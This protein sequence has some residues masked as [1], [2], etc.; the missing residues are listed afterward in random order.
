[1]IA[2]LIA[3]G[4]TGCG[5]DDESGSEQRG[6]TV[7]LVPQTTPAATATAAPPAATTTTRRPPTARRRAKAQPLA[8]VLRPY[9]ARVNRRITTVNELNVLARTPVADDFLLETLDKRAGEIFQAVYGK[10]RQKR[11]TTIVFRGDLN[12]AR[13]GRTLRNTVAAIY[14]MQATRARQIDFGSED[15]VEL[16]DW[17][18]FR[19]TVHPLLR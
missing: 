4:A 8:T 3:T 18:P 12:D 10:A 5:A 6:R 15:V 17:S 13:R 2:T 19:L 7:A 16:T 9:D 11:A 1:M 14:V